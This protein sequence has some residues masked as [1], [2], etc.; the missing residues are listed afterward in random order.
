MKDIVRLQATLRGGERTN[1]KDLKLGFVN[2]SSVFQHQFDQKLAQA[3][4]GVVL[5]KRLTV[6]NTRL[7]T[8]D[9]DLTR[10]EIEE[11]RISA[12]TQDLSRY[13]TAV[14]KK[15]QSLVNMMVSQWTAMIRDELNSFAEQNPG[16]RATVTAVIEGADLALNEEVLPVKVFIRDYRDQT[17]QIQ[18]ETSVNFVVS[19]REDK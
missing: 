3:V 14:H 18:V 5:E 15:A 8:L 4:R 6:G 2:L 1:A 12:A 19:E 11:F 10:Q 16:K 17:P 7:F 13:T 9:V